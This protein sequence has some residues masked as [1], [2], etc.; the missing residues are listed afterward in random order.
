[1]NARTKALAPIIA[2]TLIIIAALIGCKPSQQADSS[3]EPQAP[4]AGDH[5]PT[6]APSTPADGLS[7]A[8][9]TKNSPPPAPADTWEPNEAEVAY[10]AKTIYGEAAVVQ[11]KA[12]QA[13]V[14]WCILNRVDDP[15]FQ[16]TV[17]EVVTA[18]HQF[19]GYSESANPPEEY[20]ELARDILTRYHREQQGETEVG[21]TLPQGWCFFTGDGKENYF[22]EEWRGTDYWDWALPDPYTEKERS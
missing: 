13:A 9:N 2:A 4:V 22:T 10:I 8:E 17:A 11:S 21:R 19:A 1:M 3:P 18:P 7:A 16:N 12:R 20:F 6:S 15:S 14:G 5:T